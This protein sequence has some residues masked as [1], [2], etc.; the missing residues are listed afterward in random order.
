MQTEGEIRVFFDVDPAIG[1]SQDEALKRLTKFGPNKDPRLSD[2]QQRALTVRVLRQGKRVTINFKQLV[3]GDVVLLEPGNRVPADV[4]LISVDLLSVNQNGLTGEPLPAQKNTFA[5]KQQVIPKLQKNMA[6]AG[7]FV[8][9]GSGIG[10]VVARDDKTLLEK[11]PKF[12]AVKLGIKGAVIARRLRRFGVI[13]QEKRVLAKYR[14]ID[15]VIVDAELRDEEMV[16]IIRKVQLTRHIDCKFIVPA[17]SANR[18]SQ[19]L[20]AIVYDAEAK[21]GDLLASQI[22]INVD[23]P[24]SLSVLTNLKKAERQVLW[25]SDGNRSLLALSGATISLVCGSSGRDDVILAAD[26]F[27]PTSKPSILTRILYSK[28]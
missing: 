21:Q 28:H 12:R 2:S 3:P 14:K 5:L 27:A 1:L 13:V 26:I 4:R 16:E 7:S 11:S 9:S 6:F 18:L 10:V 8:T 23:K 19:E 15:T 22:L 17:S 25:V 20:G 24:N